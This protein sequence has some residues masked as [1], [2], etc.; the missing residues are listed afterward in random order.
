MSRK[1]FKMMFPRKL[2]DIKTTQ[3]KN[4]KMRKT[5]QNMNE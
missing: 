1:D 4:T 5:T 3:I 2:R